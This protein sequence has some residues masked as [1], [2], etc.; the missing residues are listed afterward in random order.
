VAFLSCADLKVAFLNFQGHEG[1]LP[2]PGWAAVDPLPPAAPARRATSDRA[3]VAPTVPSAP[4]GSTAV[5]TPASLARLVALARLLRGPR[6]LCWRCA[7][8]RD[9]RG[10]HQGIPNTPFGRTWRSVRPG[11]VVHTSEIHVSGVEVQA[12]PAQVDLEAVDNRGP[13]G[14]ARAQARTDHQSTGAAGSRRCRS[15]G[16]QVGRSTNRTYPSL[17]LPVVP[18]HGP[19]SAG[20][21]RRRSAPTHHGLCE[22][23]FRCPPAES[24][25][26]HCN[27]LTAGSHDSP[28]LPRWGDVT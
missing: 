2:E 21:E 4:E 10:Y 13:R 25:G 11:R 16:G 28:G 6:R 17:D 5:P 7:R 12:N 20:A 9:G 18:S 27:G 23:Q 15:P 22:R 1:G 14:W 26:A 8:R 19:W 3:G 24:I